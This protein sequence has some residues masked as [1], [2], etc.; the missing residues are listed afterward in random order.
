MDVKIVI[1]HPL[2]VNW[3]CCEL[4]VIWHIRPPSFVRAGS[5]CY[6]LSSKLYG[7]RGHLSYKTSVFWT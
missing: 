6:S 3:P 4:R 1:N 7:S 5:N 2:I